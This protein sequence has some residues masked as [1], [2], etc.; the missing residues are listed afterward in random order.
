MGLWD[1]FKR[2]MKK[3]SDSQVQSENFMP[4]Y[5]AKTTEVEAPEAPETEAPVEIE[6]PTTDSSDE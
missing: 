4:D 3:Q 1:S 2:F 6:A 5:S